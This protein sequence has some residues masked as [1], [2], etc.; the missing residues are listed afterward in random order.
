MQQFPPVHWF[1]AQHISVDAPQA[2]HSPLRQRFPAVLQLVSLATQALL[3]GSQ[4]APAPVQ[5]APVTQQAA[6]VAPQVEQAP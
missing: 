1:A 6:P 4:H 2:V 5:A 3:V